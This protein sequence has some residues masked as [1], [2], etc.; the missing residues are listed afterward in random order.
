MLRSLAATS[1]AGHIVSA[2]RD[3]SHRRPADV[4][5]P[6]HQNAV[7]TRISSRARRVQ[8]APRAVVADACRA[9]VKILQ[10]IRPA[11]ARPQSAD[12]SLPIRH[13]ATA[14]ADSCSTRRTKWVIYKRTTS[15]HRSKYACCRESNGC[16]LRA[17]RS[18]AVVFTRAGCCVS[19]TKCKSGW[20]A[21]AMIFIPRRRR[22]K[23]AFD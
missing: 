9:R 11:S 16:M 4:L 21:A 8:A 22:R 15:S 6:K 7:L 2:G 20:S 23:N 1:R 13:D 19:I 12:R 18:S 5:L 14:R 10:L 17:L 3:T